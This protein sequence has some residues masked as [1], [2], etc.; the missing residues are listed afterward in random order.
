MFCLTERF[1]FLRKIQL[2]RNGKLSEMTNYR[3][4]W[5]QAVFLFFR[6]C[7]N[8][9]NITVHF[10][11]SHSKIPSFSMNFRWN[12]QLHCTVLFWWEVKWNGP[13]H[14]PVPFCLLKNCTVPFAG[15]F[16]PG[17]PKKWKALKKN[18]Y[19]LQ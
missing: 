12:T 9:R 10:A 7:R 1:P 3:K 19:N 6:F 16:S 5:I 17:F 13:F 8:A 4:K 14:S 11:F 15:K 2:F 18:K